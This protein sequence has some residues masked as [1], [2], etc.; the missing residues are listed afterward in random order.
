LTLD[1][2]EQEVQAAIN[3]AGNLLPSDLPNPPIYSKVNPADTPMLTI[4]VSSDTLP[5]TKLEDL[6]DTRLAQKLSQ[7]PGVGLVSLVAASGRRCASRQS[8]GAGRAGLTLED[9]RTAISNAN[10]NQA[11]GSFDGPQQASTVDANDQL[12]SAE[13]YQNVIIAYQNGARCACGCG[14]GGGCGGKHAPGSLGR[15]Y[16]VHHPEC[17]APAGRQCHPGNRPH[18][19]LAA[20]TAVHLPA[21]WM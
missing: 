1:V 20:A 14:Q 12:K 19:G 9:I 7:V 18:Q 16:A 6:V 17:A 11:K 13:E 3:A 5:L 21:R 8:Q 2:A 4:A 10:V 15:Y